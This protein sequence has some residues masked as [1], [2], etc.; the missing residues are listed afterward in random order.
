MFL[1]QNARRGRGRIPATELGPVTL[2][3]E[4]VGAYLEGERRDLPVFSPGGYRWAPAV[5]QNVLV[6]GTGDEGGTPCVVGVQ[7]GNTPPLA[8]GEVR[9][10]STGGAAISLSN[11]GVVRLTGNVIANGE[12]LLTRAAVQQMIAQAIAAGGKGL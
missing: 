7:Q 5:E 9:I 2:E 12:A 10:A 8:P 6:L 1:A 11:S 4:T 3:G